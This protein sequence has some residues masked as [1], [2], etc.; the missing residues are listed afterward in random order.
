MEKYVGIDLG[1]TNSSVS[2][3]LNDFQPY[4]LPISMLDD[5][6]WNQ[7]EERLLP[8]VLYIKGPN[9]HCLGK[10][11]KS[12]KGQRP[13]RVIDLV[14]MDLGGDKDGKEVVYTIDG[15]KYTP[16]LISSYYLSRLRETAAKHYLYEPVNGAV[17]TVPASFDPIQV[18]STVLAAQLAGFDDEKI[19]ILSEPTAA[20]LDYIFSRARTLDFKRPKTVAVFDLGGGTCDVS[21]LRVEESEGQFG[22]YEL[23]ISR[24]S[25]IG[26][27]NFDSEVAAFYL[28]KFLQD[29]EIDFSSLD[30]TKQRVLANE[31]RVQAEVAKHVISR[32]V[33]SIAAEPN[34]KLWWDTY[35]NIKHEYFMEHL[36]LAYNL[37]ISAAEYDQIIYPLLHDGPQNIIDPISS[38]L[39]KAKKYAGVSDI[40]NLFLVGGMTSYPAVEKRVSEYFN[41]RPLRIPDRMLSVSRGAAIAHYLKDRVQVEKVSHSG[42][43]SL[44]E[45]IH[46]VDIGNRIAE[47]IFVMVDKGLPVPVLEAGT[48]AGEG[49]TKMGEF[50]T[51]EDPYG[52]QLQLVQGES[53]FS[54]IFR[55]LGQPAQ[56]TFS[57]PMKKGEQVSLRVEFREN[58]E[59]FVKAWLD[60]YP[61][62]TVQV[63]FGKILTQKEIEEMSARRGKVE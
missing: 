37:V 34:S 8:S 35:R 2:V 44:N 58:R 6:G 38:A 16:E 14:K 63:T 22:I 25:D 30:V 32:D 7:V 15:V 9:I 29:T 27:R 41:C 12:M 42:T 18:N 40:D 55:S 33:Q 10:Y 47:T 20:I 52:L 19:R 61:N 53:R 3:L 23:G 11:A 21:V 50:F 31:Y 13:D 60:N 51:G 39:K 24:F 28:N 43:G 59:I 49:Q 36:G 4:T 46:N 56:L 26:G 57:R 17:I 48:P 45:I 5:F 54:T 1:T 62:E